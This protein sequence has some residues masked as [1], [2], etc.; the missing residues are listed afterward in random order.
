MAGQSASIGANFSQYVG[1]PQLGGGVDIGVLNFDTKPLEDLGKYTMLFNKAEQ[2][3]R[4]KKEAEAVAELANL[5]S[6]DLTSA[7]AKD[8][9]VIEK[10]Y[11]D[12]FNFVRENPTVLD[13]K[14]NPQGF[15]EY[16]KRKNELQNT[17]K[18]GKGR[19][20]SVLARQERIA[21][22]P[23]PELKA[24]MQ[25]KL[26][27]EIAATDIKT[28]I[29]ITEEFDL[30][31]VEIFTPGRIKVDQTRIDPNSNE[32]VEV[33]YDFPDV[34]AAKR[35]SEGAGLG[36]DALNID[37][38]SPEFVSKTPEQQKRILDNYEAQKKGGKLLAAESAAAFN[39]AWQQYGG[40]LEKIK[41]SNPLLAGVVNTLQQANAYLE[42]KTRNIDTG[43]FK[44]K[45]VSLQFG[46]KGLNRND[47][48]P[49]KFQDGNLR[50]ADILFAQSLGKAASDSFD[51]KVTETDNQL[52]KDQLAQKTINDA[53]NRAIERA[54]L[55]QTQRQW[56]AGINSTESIKNSAWKYGQDIIGQLDKIKDKGSAILPKDF[57]KLN[58]EILMAL[59]SELPELRDDAG[60]IIRAAGFYPLE[61]KPGNVIRV[62]G[63]QV[64]VY[65]N[66]AN[67]DPNSSG[68]K[69][70]S[71]PI[72][73]TSLANIATNRLIREVR[74]S[75]GK[76]IGLFSGVD[77]DKA[78]VTIGTTK[79]QTS[80]GSSSS[81][82]GIGYSN[83]TE[84]DA[85]TLG[86]KDGKW[87]NIK[88]GKIV[89]GQ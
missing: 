21:K 2:E 66:S 33:T 53:E 83:I 88:T 38:N 12:L 64:S 20:I 55:A 11:N 74:A 27:E 49:I 31:P 61:L 80:K 25:K 34:G 59:G 24:L 22:E 79:T 82:S 28:P 15:L 60:K 89:P 26:D 75:G 78:P 36:I 14:N 6:Y 16:G 46:V 18:G 86:V 47:Y 48:A 44:D 84:T 68:N 17:I 77:A 10:G 76:E 50:A 1:N 40:D 39:A 30:K 5:A 81:K 72:K 45:G 69:F 7:V 71:N 67:P 13:Y 57:G 43:M 85:G 63:D 41:A 29:R 23:N 42:D 9:Q 32:N 65:D 3:E 56:E 87:Y 54:R 62:V 4:Q 35:W 58:N 52:Q 73:S 19:T 70:S 8:R 37:V 51:T